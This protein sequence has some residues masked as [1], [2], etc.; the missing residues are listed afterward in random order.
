MGDTTMIKLVSERKVVNKTVIALLVTCFLL[1]PGYL[2][3]GTPNTQAFGTPHKSALI[4]NFEELIDR[5]IEHR[6]LPSHQMTPIK[7]DVNTIELLQ[8]LNET[9]ILG[10]LENLTAFGPRE[11][12]TGACNQAAH[13][14][15][16]TFQDM[17]LNVRY[18]NY[19]DGR[20]SG[21]DIEA[22]LY[23]SDSTN[24][25]IICGHYDTVPA[26]SGADDDGSGVAAVLAVAEIMSKYKFDHTVRFVA[27][28][29]EEQGLIGSHCYAKDARNNNES[30]VA[31]LNADMIGF[32]AT[33][34]DGIQ[35]NI[36][37]NNASEWIVNFT[38]DISQVYTDYIGIQLLPQG[39][40]LGSD[41]FSFWGYGYDA[42]LYQ[43][44][45]FN[46]YHHSAGDIIAHMNIAYATRFSRLIL[47]TLAE[48]AQ[49]L[50]NTPPI[51]DAGPDQFVF[52][53]A[54]VHLDGSGSSD[55]DGDPLAFIWS[56]IDKPVGST[57]VLSDPYIMNPMF[58]ADKSGIYI[59]QL[60][61]KDRNSLSIPDMVNINTQNRPP[62]QPS[63]PNPSN[64]TTVV[65]ITTG[66][67]WT[68]S[69]PDAGDFVFY[70]V[71]FGSM[72]P[73][74]KIASNISA[75]S[76]NPG[77]LAYSLTYFWKIVAWDNHGLSTDGPVWYFTTINT[78]N[79][80]PPDKP[81]TPQGTANGKI[82]VVYTY[83]TST[84]DPDGDQVYYLWDWGDGTTSAWLGPYNSGAA[85]S[86]TH[87]WIAKGSYNIKVKAKNTYGKESSYSD[88]LPITMPYVYKPILQFLEWL[89]QRFPHTFPILQ[90]LL[91]Y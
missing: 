51:A 73:L 29:G 68:D 75:K 37:E 54:T 27:F 13:Y 4:Q 24:I 3:A 49:Q 38:K 45:H 44:Y 18:Y 80:N 82:N 12:G 2:L 6:T 81:S 69:D 66:L 8:Q 74:E 50:I 65:S 22:T 47:A 20:I 34:S 41:H 11:T 7:T 72:P 19:T 35:G 52:I 61:V 83:T 77:T 67:S 14:L 59:L 25:F 62:N 90:H 84:T 85:I 91:G 56:F 39:K 89:F 42:V 46:E 10:Y 48:M 1:I 57:A 5:E 28:S 43:E 16:K 33:P 31:V 70:D 9:L 36:F 79:K 88:P 60:V 40:N 71:Y 87:I 30:I 23:G 15:Y 78:T 26:G 21:S 53:G 17:G 58:V 86:T 63:D 32:T 76:Y 55:E 64:G